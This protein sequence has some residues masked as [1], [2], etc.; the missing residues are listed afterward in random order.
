LFPRAAINLV[1]CD[2]DSRF[3]IGI[4]NNGR[5]IVDG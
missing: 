3:A 5:E 4:A 2:T 1:V